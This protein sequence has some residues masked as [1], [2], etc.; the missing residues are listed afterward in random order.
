MERP[1]ASTLGWIGV[2]G[3]VALYDALCPEGEQLSERA[4]EWLEHPFKRR[5]VELGMAAVA[6]HV[7]NRIPEQFDVIHHLASLRRKDK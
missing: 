3:G 6:L 2:I 4:D 7:C 5:I 1:R